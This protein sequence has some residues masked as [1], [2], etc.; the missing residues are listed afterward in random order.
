MSII[1]LKAIFKSP[2]TTHNMT[3][4]KQYVESLNEI[5]NF[6]QVPLFSDQQWERTGEQIDVLYHGGKEKIEK[7]D[8]SFLQDRDH[9]FFGEGFYLADSKEMARNYGPVITEFDVKNEANILSPYKPG[10]TLNKGYDPEGA[11]DGFMEE[12]LRFSHSIGKKRGRLDRWEEQETQIRTD[13]RTFI[14]WTDF[15]ALEKG[16]DMIWWSGSEI[17]VKNFQVIKQ[18]R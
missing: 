15:Y 11:Y 8:P 6:E 14:D 1:S 3:S 7:I 2:A 17:V 13:H 16:Y 18:R 12:I 9:G 4:F 10:W 5:S